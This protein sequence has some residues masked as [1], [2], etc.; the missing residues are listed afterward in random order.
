[1]SV[2]T[3]DGYSPLMG[4]ASLGRTE[5]VVVLVKGGADLNLQNK[6]CHTCVV[7]CQHVVMGSV[8]WGVCGNVISY[9]ASV[10]VSQRWSVYCDIHVYHMEKRV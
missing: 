10:E 7:V 2:I 5:A 8:C 4:A 1:M 3:Q 6:V 9:S